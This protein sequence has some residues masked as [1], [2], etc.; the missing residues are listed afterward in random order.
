MTLNNQG[1]NTSNVK[2]HD[3]MY[4]IQGP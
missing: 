4:T 2:L 1:A 3:C